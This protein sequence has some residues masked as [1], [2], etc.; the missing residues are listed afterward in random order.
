MKRLLILV[1]L[2][3]VATTAVAQEAGLDHTMYRMGIPGG[4]AVTPDLVGLVVSQPESVELVYFNTLTEKEVKRVEM[5]FKPGALAI[6]EKTLF[7]AGK[8]SSVVYQLELNS[9]KEQKQFE[10]PGDAISR[11]AVHPTKPLLF[12]S[13]SSF[14]V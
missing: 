5:D 6:K 9:A 11:I 7:A 8:G 2:S 3:A 10:I 13:T 1:A 12:A 4:F 14:Q